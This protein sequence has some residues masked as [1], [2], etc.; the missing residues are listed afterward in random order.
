MDFKKESPEECTEAVIR[1][2]RHIGSSRGLPF[3]PDKPGCPMIEAFSVRYVLSLISG[4]GVLEMRLM[5]IKPEEQRGRTPLFGNGTLSVTGSTFELTL[6]KEA[7]QEELYNWHIKRQ[8]TG[9]WSVLTKDFLEKLIR[10][11]L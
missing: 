5:F 11:H 3:H 7:G 6:L 2:L 10:T 1:Y 8:E 4:K 9:N